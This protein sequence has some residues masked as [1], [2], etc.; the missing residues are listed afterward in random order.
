MTTE[1]EVWDRVVGVDPKRFYEYWKPG[2]KAKWKV[3]EYLSWIMH[4]CSD[5]KMDWGEIRS[6]LISYLEKHGK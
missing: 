2:L 6:I 4:S 1:K 3:D 5:P